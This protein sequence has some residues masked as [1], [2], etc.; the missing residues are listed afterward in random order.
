MGPVLLVDDDQELQEL[1]REILEEAGYCVTEA[2]DG[3]TA[4]DVLRRSRSSGWCCWIRL[5]PHGDGKH[6]LQAVSQ[7]GALS[8]RHSYVLLTART[9]L[10]LPVLELANSL[11]IPVMRKPF[12]LEVS[13]F[14]G[15]AGA[16]PDS[17]GSAGLKRNL[18]RERACRPAG[19]PGPAR[20]GLVLST[21]APLTCWRHAVAGP[22]P[23]SAG[24]PGRR[25]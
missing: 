6:V 9:R 8:T 15:G 20:P 7:A 24:F 19:R 22:A 12:E 11:S 25:A 3:D 1:L 18:T 14:N 21:I 17:G 2:A 5:L 13:A 4:L 16:Q 10:S 23:V